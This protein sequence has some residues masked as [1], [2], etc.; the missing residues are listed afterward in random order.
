MRI[1]T[2]LPISIV[3]LILTSIGDLWRVALSVLVIIGRVG[4]LRKTTKV[5]FQRN[6]LLP[7]WKRRGKEGERKLT[8]IISPPSKQQQ[9][10]LTMDATPTFQTPP[11]TGS[12]HSIKQD[13]S[14]TASYYYVMWLLYW[15][16]KWYIE[17]LA[18]W[19][20][21][22]LHV[23]ALWGGDRIRRRFLSPTALTYQK[24]QGG[25]VFWSPH[26]V[27]KSSEI[28]DWWRFRSPQ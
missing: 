15:C 10:I 25:F 21:G 28:D 3:F 27:S 2:F 9:K 14:G 22:G 17:L 8:P 7:M 11:L 12:R 20:H 26:R 19:R 23:P 1:T 5:I 24:R 4:R 6:K 13:H 16:S 18:W